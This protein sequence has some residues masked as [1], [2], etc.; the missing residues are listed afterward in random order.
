MI[1]SGDWEKPNVIIT[2]HRIGNSKKYIKRI[3]H[4]SLTQELLFYH[5]KMASKVFCNYWFIYMLIINVYTSG[6][7]SRGYER[8]TDAH[9]RAL[10]V[11]NWKQSALPKGES[12]FVIIFFPTSFQLWK[13]K[14]ALS[15]VAK[16]NF[17]YGCIVSIS[18]HFTVVYVV[19]VTVRPPLPAT[20]LPGRHSV[21]TLTLG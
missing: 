4:S 1:N 20:F 2:R 13:E 18:L 11:G 3:I 12:V 5:L 21:H 7:A 14:K 19:V 17:W 10:S 16:G 8:E 9:K 6:I 15:F